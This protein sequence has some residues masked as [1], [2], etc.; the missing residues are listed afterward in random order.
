[1][2]VAAWSV[3]PEGPKRLPIGA[4][5]LEKDLESWIERD[6]GL[7]DPSLLVV[8]RQMHVEGGIL[9]L[10]CVDLQGRLV[11]V[12]I[13]RAQLMREVIAQGLDYASCIAAM[14]IESVRERIDAYLGQPP[15]HPGLAALLS[16]S[17]DDEREVAVI[18]VG[19]GEY[20][21]LQRLIDFLGTN[22]SIPIRA[23]SFDVFELDD[24]AKVLVREDTEPEVAPTAQPGPKYTR[25]GVIAAAGGDGSPM[26]RR[27][28]KIIE[29]AERSGLYARPYKVSFMLTPP[30]KKTRYLLVMGQWQRPG[31]LNISYAADAISEFFP[32]E[33]DVVRLIL[34]P[35]R[36]TTQIATDEDAHRWASGIEELF[37][38]IRGAS[39]EIVPM[40]ATP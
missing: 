6:I 23:V 39:P 20:S 36:Q 37:A 30:Q 40:E 3:L 14:P 8:Q 7:I 13:K 28:L 9:D 27:M 25:D 12:E 26:A 11:V 17:A 32:V 19:V 29:A 15:D 2:S 18:V 35:D 16:G 24:G 22:Y 34:G 5:P 33:P 31:E 10:L 38:H 21:G 4:V 1:M